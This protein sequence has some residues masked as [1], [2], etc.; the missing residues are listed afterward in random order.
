MTRRKQCAA[1]GLAMVAT[2]WLPSGT[3]AQAKRSAG[4]AAKKVSAAAVTRCGEGVT[5]SVSP[6]RAVQGGLVLAEARG[7]KALVSVKG[8]WN[9]REVGFWN[10]GAASPASKTDRWRGLLGVDLEKPAGVYELTVFVTREGSDA[11]GCGAKVTVVAG[12]FPTERLTVDDQFVEPSPEQIQRVEEEGEKLRKIYGTATPERLWHGKFRLPLDNVTTGG[13][14]GRR[15]VLNGTPRSP[16]SG[17]DFPAPTGTPV[18]ATQAGRVVLAEPLFFAGNAVVVDHG[19][20]IY[21]FYGHLSAIYVKAGDEVEAGTVLG[22]VGATG[23]VTGPH[24]HW[25]LSVNR[26]RAN[27]MELVRVLGAR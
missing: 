27:A 15:R 13:N 16:H 20:G 21:T 14:F 8:S 26:D 4:P 22:E 6:A 3:A 2:I 12:R 5:L 1:L 23:R 18:H 10:E 9:G 25:G 24:L 11:V 19:L 7:A 17:V